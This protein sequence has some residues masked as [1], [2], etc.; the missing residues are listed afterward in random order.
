GGHRDSTSRSGIATVA[1]AAK[2]RKS[3]SLISQFYVTLGGKPPDRSGKLEI[4]PL[5]V[6]LGQGDGF[7]EGG[8]R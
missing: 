2:V 8:R 5:N 1:K 6:C 4:S 3:V 7:I